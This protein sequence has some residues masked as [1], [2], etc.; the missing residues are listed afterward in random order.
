MLL[1]GAAAPKIAAQLEGL[2]LVDSGKIERAV[3]LGGLTSQ[4][5]RCRAAGAGMREF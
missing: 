3:R 2:P 5:R 4:R 1:I